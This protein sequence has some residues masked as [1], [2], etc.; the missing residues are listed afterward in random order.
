MP[1]FA[2]RENYRLSD[3]LFPLALNYSAYYNNQRA[4]SAMQV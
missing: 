4:K 1:L 3:S 2:V